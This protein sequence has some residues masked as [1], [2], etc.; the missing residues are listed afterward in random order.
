LAG[1]LLILLG[2]LSARAQ[3]PARLALLIGNQGC[4]EKVGPL[5]NP[6]H[7]IAIVGKAFEADGFKVTAIRDAGRWQVLSAVQAFAA[8]LA[9]GGSNAVGFF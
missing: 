1:L 8:E 4:S 7:D 3:D 9:K 6:H 2:S 5:K